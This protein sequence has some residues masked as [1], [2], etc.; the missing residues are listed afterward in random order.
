MSQILVELIEH[1]DERGLAASALACLDR[2]LPLLDPAPADEVL[3]ALWAAVARG[4]E[5]W[6]GRLAEAQD[7]VA[8]DGEPADDEGALV[9]RMLGDAPR[10][11]A[12]EP[13]A[14][15]ADACS[16]TALALHQQLEPGSSGTPERCRAGDPDG[17]GP[18]VDGELRRQI[19]ILEV[20]AAGGAGG[21]RLTRDITAEG[22][23]VLRAVVSRRARSA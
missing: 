23:R 15:W 19:R 14:R 4:E 5:G 21:L 2:C 1:A 11:W 17:A 9:R 22:R 3:R 18:L 12:R 8:R 20:L 10:V 16:L 13:L 7:T 6:A